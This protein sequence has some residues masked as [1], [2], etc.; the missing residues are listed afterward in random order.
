MKQRCY[1]EKDK[2]YP[3]Q[4]ALGIV[5]CEEWRNSFAQFLE[6]MGE[7]PEGT[8]LRRYSNYDNYTMKNCHWRPCK[9]RPE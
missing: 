6:D 4:G 9:K 1:Y 8:A 3:T 2:G 7:A 5:M